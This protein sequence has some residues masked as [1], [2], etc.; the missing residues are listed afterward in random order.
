M[1][2]E[3]GA[4]QEGGG[5]GG[6]EERKSDQ[7]ARVPREVLVD[8]KEEEEKEEEGEGR[9]GERSVYERFEVTANFARR[10]A[11][12]FVAATAPICLPVCPFLFL[13]LFR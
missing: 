5:G 6:G 3:V 7:E 11:A 12:T 2:E 9:K 10:P 4:G 13:S 1:T 8:E